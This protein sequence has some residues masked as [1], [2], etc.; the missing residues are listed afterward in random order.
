MEDINSSEFKELVL[1][2][3]HSGN[4]TKD[5]AKALVKDGQIEF[6][7]W[8]NMTEFYNSG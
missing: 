5:E 8:L 1:K 2:S 6:I 7:F 3:L 4:V